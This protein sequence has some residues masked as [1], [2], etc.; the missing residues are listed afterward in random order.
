MTSPGTKVD[1]S[2]SFTRSFPRCR[3]ISSLAFRSSSCVNGAHVGQLAK[4]EQ[5]QGK[6]R[7]ERAK[8]EWEV[9]AE[10]NI[11]TNLRLPH[12]V[13]NLLQLLDV[14]NLRLYLL[15]LRLGFIRCFPLLPLLRSRA[16][17]GRGARL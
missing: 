12:P 16:I 15:S 5:G 9:D 1:T 11:S 10:I 2:S 6:V 17:K 3:Y 14:D 8:Q 13:F 4:E 7:H